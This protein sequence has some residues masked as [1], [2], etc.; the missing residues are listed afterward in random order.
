MWGQGNGKCIMFCKLRQ[1]KVRDGLFYIHTLIIYLTFIQITHKPIINHSDLCK[2]VLLARK[3]RITKTTAYILCVRTIS[4]PKLWRCVSLCIKGSLL[5]VT[6]LLLELV[7]FYIS[8]IIL[9]S[10]GFILTIYLYPILVIY[11]FTKQALKENTFNEHWKKLYTQQFS[12]EPL[13]I[14]HYNSLCY[15]S[16]S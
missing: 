7:T 10:L 16:Y 1:M 11:Y 14:S 4:L 5:K 15:I 9:K 6:Y 12:S 8:V 2:W 3:G 13:S